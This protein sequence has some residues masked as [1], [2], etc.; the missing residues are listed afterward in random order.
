ML[1]DVR[2]DRGQVAEFAERGFP[3]IPQAVPQ[4]LVAAGSRVIDRLAERYPPGPDVRGPHNYFPAAER[5]PALAALLT[6]GPAFALAESLTGPGTLEV[7]GQVQAVLTIPPFPHRPGMH[8]IDGFPA[9][10]DGRP[11]TFPWLDYDTVRATT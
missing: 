11:G 8:H 9:E 6:G 1:D 7:P 4:E 10:P 3:L 5:V 2:L